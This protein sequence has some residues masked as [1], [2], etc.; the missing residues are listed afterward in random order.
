MFDTAR[1]IEHCSSI[2][3]LEEGDSILTGT[4]RRRVLSVLSDH[5]SLLSVT[6]HARRSLQTQGVGP[7]NVGDKLEATLL[8]DDETLASWTGSAVARKGGYVFSSTT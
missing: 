7:V 2:M 3:T 6:H 4:V 5:C 8:Q 1:L